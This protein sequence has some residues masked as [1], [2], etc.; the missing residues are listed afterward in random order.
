M[1]NLAPKFP[2]VP[3]CA[4]IVGR[5][6][7]SRRREFAGAR[8]IPKAGHARPDAPGQW[9]LVRLSTISRSGHAWSYPHDFDNK[10]RSMPDGCA[11][12][13]TPAYP[14]RTRGESR[15]E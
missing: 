15:A 14:A 13:E 8:G 12:A 6:F 3:V 11:A 1:G 2:L 4:G 7:S 9:N 5:K 10:L